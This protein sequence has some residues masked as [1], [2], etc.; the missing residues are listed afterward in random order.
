MFQPGGMHVQNHLPV[1]YAESGESAGHR[2]PVSARGRYVDAPGRDLITRLAGGK[3]VSIT[4][5][6]C[7]IMLIFGLVHLHRGLPAGHGS[8]G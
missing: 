8:V 4:T 2:L 5:P 3:Q 7:S 6:P 1:A